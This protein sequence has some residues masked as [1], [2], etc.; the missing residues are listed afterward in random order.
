MMT[1]SPGTRTARSDTRQRRIESFAAEFALLA[2]RRARLVHQM[3]LLDQQR[4]AAANNF[5]KL[6]ARMS[7]LVQRMDALDPELRDGFEPEPEP[8]APPPP[9]PAA[10][11]IFAPA[12][13]M[14]NK[15]PPLAQKLASRQPWI[16]GRSAPQSRPNGG[17]WRS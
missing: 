16:P 15:T 3:D 10:R 7:W 4:E 5:A 2:Q 6:Q 11:P 13:K 12:P 1:R 14:A 17:K 9:P 8:V